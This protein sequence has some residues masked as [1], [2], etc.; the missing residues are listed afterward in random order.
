MK[1][2][3]LISL[4]VDFLVFAEGAG[5]AKRIYSVNI[6]NDQQL[7]VLR[8]LHNCPDGIEFQV[9]PTRVGE[10]VDL[11]IPP[12]KF[13]DISELFDTY[14]FT[15]RISTRNLQEYEIKTE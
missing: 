15:N 4:V 5:Y 1:L 9:N 6:E 14:K 12:H 11:I 10:I 3:V 7:N 13:A 2:I 8:D